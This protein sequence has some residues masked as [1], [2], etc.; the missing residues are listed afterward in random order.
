MPHPGSAIGTNTIHIVYCIIIL[1]LS[2]NLMIVGVY[3]WYMTDISRQT[4]VCSSCNT[5]MRACLICMPDYPKA[6]GPR[7]EGIHIRQS[8]NAP[9]Y[10]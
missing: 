3:C 7:A 4:I 1:S 8:P 10:N 6:T 2:P 5:G 9:C